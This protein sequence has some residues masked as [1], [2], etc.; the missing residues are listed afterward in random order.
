[1]KPQKADFLILIVT[2]CWGSSY[3][4]MKIGLDSLSAFNIVALRYG[5]AFI[6][7][8]PILVIRFRS[9]NLKSVIFSFGLGFL[10][11]AVSASIIF[12]LKNTTASKAGF[13][14]SLT[15]IFVPLLSALIIKKKPE[16]NV[17][18]G[19]FASIV[20]IGLLTLNDRMSIMP[21]DFL[22]MLAALLYAFH[23]LL[24]GSAAKVA[25]VINLGILQLG[26]AGGFGLLFA[27]IFEVPKLPSSYESWKAVLVLSVVCSAFA[28]ITQTIAQKYTTPT[29]TG[30]IFSL[31]PVFAAVFAYLSAHELLPIKGYV[32]AAF[33][34]LG[35]MIAE[36]KR[37]NT[38]SI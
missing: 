24:T 27:F 13:L 2:M 16:L 17:I 28:Y 6:I 33:I 31:E 35:V 8:L 23:I 18:A 9:I 36:I 22:C 32:G 3:L 15:V 7:C 5:L 10:L 4:F 21:G 12:G 26:F 19:V 38:S 29:H 25:D 34:L 37:L 11:F 14:A 1:M 20:G 30:L